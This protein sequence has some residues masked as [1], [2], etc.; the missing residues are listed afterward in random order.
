MA[1][2]T[3]CRRFR[4]SFAIHLLDRGGDLRAIQEL[5]GFSDVRATIIFT[6][7]LNFG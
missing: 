5:L 7:V 1:K 2:A 3:S 4:H 6:Y